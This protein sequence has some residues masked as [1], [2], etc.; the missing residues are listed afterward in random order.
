M[1][2]LDFGNQKKVTKSLIPFPKM[3]IVKKVAVK[4]F[5]VVKINRP[6][7]ARGDKCTKRI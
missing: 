4:L 2:K 5:N 7:R 6:R 3:S 1:T